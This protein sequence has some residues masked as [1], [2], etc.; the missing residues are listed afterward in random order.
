MWNVS[1]SGRPLASTE[2]SLLTGI[3]KAYHVL[4]LVVSLKL[5]TPRSLHL[6]T[7]V[8]LSVQW[9]VNMLL[10]YMLYVK[11]YLCLVGL[12]LVS[13]RHCSLLNGFNMG[14]VALTVY[15]VLLLDIALNKQMALQ[16]FFPKIEMLYPSSYCVP[17]NIQRKSNC[18]CISYDFPV[19]PIKMNLV[20]ILCGQKRINTLFICHHAHQLCEFNYVISKVV[21]VCACVWLLNE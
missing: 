17:D 15:L 7:N 8:F 14:E 11:S 10:L 5:N 4:P 19:F 20:V 9:H 1:E 21:C 6:Q 3:R 18:F 16:W 13:S 2:Y 12:V